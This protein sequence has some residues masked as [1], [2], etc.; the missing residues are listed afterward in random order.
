MKNLRQPDDKV[1]SWVS[2][3]VKKA[4]N[5]SW[6]IAA[7][8]VGKVLA[9]VFEQLLWMVKVKQSTLNLWK[10]GY[11]YCRS[12]ELKSSSLR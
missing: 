7:G 10:N 2:D 9:D 12:V 4:L 6:K 3:I 11:L 1:E 8:A 5:G